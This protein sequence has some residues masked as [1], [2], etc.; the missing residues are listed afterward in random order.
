MHFDQPSLFPCDGLVV[1]E[2]KLTAFLGSLL[3][4]PLGRILT[5]SFHFLYYFNRLMVSWWSSLSG[6]TARWEV[7]FRFPFLLS[8]PIIL[9]GP[10]IPIF[11][12]FSEMR[13]FILY[14]HLSRPPV[15]F[16]SFSRP[17]VLITPPCPEFTLASLQTT[18]PLIFHF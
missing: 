6:G 4:G 12:H 3:L 1:V 2:L 5:F 7:S 17:R 11:M 14:C 8:P 9:H 13:L 10:Q 16:P 18:S 15:A